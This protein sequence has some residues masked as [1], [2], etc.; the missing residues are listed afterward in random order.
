MNRFVGRRSRNSTDGL[1]VERL[2][3]IPAPTNQIE[4]RLWKQSHL[5]YIRSYPAGLWIVEQTNSRL[6]IKFRSTFFFHFFL[7]VRTSIRGER[8][9]IIKSI[10]RHR[11][12]K[13]ILF[14]FFLPLSIYLSVSLFLSF[15]LSVFFSFF[16]RFFL[17]V[18]LEKNYY[19]HRPWYVIIK[20]IY[21]ECTR[22]RT[23]GPTCRCNARG[24]SP[25]KLD[26]SRKSS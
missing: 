9:N 24:P 8:I 2:F 26:F 23:V 4:F 13:K 12:L 3:Q 15:F 14:S 21:K 18:S 19:S 16:F 7:H 20:S 5:L 6:N 17:K 22:T 25:W 1:K 11:F 10:F